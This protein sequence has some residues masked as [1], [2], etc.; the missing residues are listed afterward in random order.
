MG[1]IYKMSYNNL[2]MNLKVAKH[3]KQKCRKLSY[4]VE[5]ILLVTVKSS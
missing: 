3:G 5:A 4:K 1:D 2:M